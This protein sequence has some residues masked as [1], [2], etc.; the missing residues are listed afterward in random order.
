MPELPEVETVCSGL[1]PH[2][3]EQTIASVVL[4][5]KML[6][7]P[8]PKDLAQ[9]LQ[10]RRVVSLFRR[11]KYLCFR[12]DD[13]V[14]LVWHLGMTGQFHCLS[15]DD[16]AGK[17]EHIRI[18]FQ[19]GMSLRYRDA[20]RFGFVQLMAW[21]QWQQQACFA[22]LGPEPLSDAFT[23]EGLKQWCLG[24]KQ[25][26]KACLMDASC[27]VGVGNIYASESLF[28]AGIHPARAAGR[29][30]LQRYQRLTVIIKQVLQEA[31]AAGGSSIRDFV[32]ADGKPG[33]FSH[34]FAVY[35]RESLPCPDC[36]A[37]IKRLLL[38]GRSSF[39]CPHC[40]H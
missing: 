25:S 2:V 34:Q 12:L 17:H 15:L 3:L 20:R 40:Q 22:R 36:S 30:S 24:K 21:D 26:I 31:I 28:R 32:Q 23:A 14:L 6:R 19:H 38:A 4:G 13:D 1:R 35:G 37:P 5:E 16:A 9:R 11:S 10:G 8:W 27:V 33:Y 29:I 18:D 39:Y 7:F